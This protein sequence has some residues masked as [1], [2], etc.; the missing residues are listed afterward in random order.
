MVFGK[1]IGYLFYTDYLQEAF[2]LRFCSCDIVRTYGRV[3]GWQARRWRLLPSIYSL[4]MDG[5]RIIDFS[6]D[7]FLSFTNTIPYYL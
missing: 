1:K 5:E 6:F 7:Y 2:S 4:T 3:S